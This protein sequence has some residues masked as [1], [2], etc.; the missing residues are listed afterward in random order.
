MDSQQDFVH[1]SPNFA[2]MGASVR[3]SQ[4]TQWRIPIQYEHEIYLQL[5][6]GGNKEAEMTANQ[7][8]LEERQ[9]RLHSRANDPAVAGPQSTPSPTDFECAAT[10]NV[11]R[12]EHGGSLIAQPS[13]RIRGVGRTS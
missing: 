6:A 13:Q 8:Y 11:R 7:L 5:T 1:F 3:S 10:Q 9:R 4:S 2:Q 12:A